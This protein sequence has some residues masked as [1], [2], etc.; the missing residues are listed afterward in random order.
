ML[1]LL[2]CRCRRFGCFSASIRSM[3]LHSSCSKGLLGMRSVHQLIFSFFRGLDPS[4]WRR[5]RVEG[6]ESV[7]QPARRHPEGV[8]TGFRSRQQLL[9]RA[10]SSAREAALLSSR[11]FSFGKKNSSTN[12]VH[13]VSALLHIPLVPASQIIPH[14]RQ[15]VQVAS[16]SSRRIQPVD[17]PR[18][19]R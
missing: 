12:H 18:G 16:R 10:G 7:A 1:N 14:L 15:L 19:F 17:H 13:K 5:W 9:R 4:A 3:G 8:G 2:P 6:G 11:C